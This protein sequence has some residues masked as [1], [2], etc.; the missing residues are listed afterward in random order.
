MVQDLWYKAFGL[1]LNKWHNTHLWFDPGAFSCRLWRHWGF[2]LP[3]G[4]GKRTTEIVLIPG[5]DLVC[6]GFISV[7]SLGYK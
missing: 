4:K 5:L 2:A 3:S 1:D 7:L 6:N